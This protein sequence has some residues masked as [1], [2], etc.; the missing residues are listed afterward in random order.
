MKDNIR[1]LAS[2]F[3]ALPDA[4]VVVDATGR[5]V[6]ANAAV[7]PV[8]G[9][10]VAELTGQTLARL[11]PER[12]RA[13]HERRFAEYL[14]A[15]RPTLMGSR[16]I[17]Y[18]VNGSGVEVPVSISLA[19][20]DLDRERYS[21][22]VIRDASPAHDRL[23]DVMM[24]SETDPLTGLANRLGALRCMRD[25]IAADRPFALLI[26]DLQR[27]G[28]FNAVEGHRIDDEVLRIVARR[29]EA[30]VRA[31]DL[32]ARL[33]GD[34]FAFVVQGVSDRTL[35][36]HPFRV[37][38]VT[39]AIGSH[40]GGALFPADGRTEFEL[41]RAAHQAVDRATEAGWAC[42]IVGD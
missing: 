15:G 9:Y 6:L 25:T 13:S 32:A 34:E 1:A 29:L 23:G 36:R 8:L 27:F 38:A 22:A 11:I 18:A 5:I 40:I 42:W 39:G 7:G 19:N 21:V 30:V 2:V 12:F 37:D 17:L 35:V 4:V 10:E 28:P 16:P 31:G 14:G 33:G 3:D 41:L 24:Q 20:L 26:L